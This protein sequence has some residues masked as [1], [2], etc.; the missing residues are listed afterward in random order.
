MFVF[1]VLPLALERGQPVGGNGTATVSDGVLEDVIA[2]VAMSG[3]PGRLATAEQQA[4]ADYE[5]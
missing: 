3:P 1:D 2:S 5:E 4:D